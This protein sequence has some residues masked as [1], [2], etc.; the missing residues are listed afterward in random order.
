ML[1]LATTIFNFSQITNSSI[2]VLPEYHIIL[3]AGKNKSDPDF[4]TTNKA[5][6]KNTAK[7]KGTFDLLAHKCQIFWNIFV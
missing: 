4:Q 5:N 3:E 6:E 7:P 2:Q 1:L